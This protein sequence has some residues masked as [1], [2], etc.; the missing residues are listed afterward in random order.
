MITT[1]I[2][3]SNARKGT[4]E[5]VRGKTAMGPLNHLKEILRASLTFMPVQERMCT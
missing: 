4:I 2:S 1:A 3:L 5:P